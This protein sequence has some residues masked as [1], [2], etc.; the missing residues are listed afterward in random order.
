MGLRSG[1]IAVALG[2]F[3]LM[4]AVSTCLAGSAAGENGASTVKIAELKRQQQKSIAP[5]RS[6]S[7]M[8]AQQLQNEL[9]ALQQTMAEVR[10]LS[11]RLKNHQARLAG[12]NSKMSSMGEQ[13][14]MMQLQLQQAMNRQSQMMQTMSAIMKSMHDTQKSIINNMR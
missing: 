11:E 10:R 4:F 9:K 2:A 12:L 1:I 8:L 14:Q 13:N 3:A 6:D 5:K 7:G